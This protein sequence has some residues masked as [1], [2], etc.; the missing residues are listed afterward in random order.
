M[1]DGKKVCTLCYINLPQSTPRVAFVSTYYRLA[2]NL[3][4][5]TFVFAA[6]N[7]DAAHGNQAIRLGSF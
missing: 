1:A 4:Q 5:I 2:L 3:G 7:G 6:S